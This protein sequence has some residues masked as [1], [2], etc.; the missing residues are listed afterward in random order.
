VIFTVEILRDKG[1]PRYAVTADK[2]GKMEKVGANGVRFTFKQ[3]DR[4]LPLILANMPVLARHAID[5]A[6][7][8]KSTLKPMVGSGPYTLDIV[9]PGESLTFKRNPDYWAK[10]IPSKRASTIT[11]RSRWLIIVTRTPCLKRSRKR[12]DRR[13][14]R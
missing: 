13:P 8:D 9:K 6:T 2:I 7:F 4:E 12:P 5:P 10:D 3:P 1:L 14:D 11:I